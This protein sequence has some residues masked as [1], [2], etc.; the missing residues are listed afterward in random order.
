MRLL[1]PS[2]VMPIPA[3]SGEP[4]RAASGEAG[5]VLRTAD[6]GAPYSREVATFFS[7]AASAPPLRAS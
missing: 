6:G 2:V 5:R 1:L 4:S 3:A 7:S